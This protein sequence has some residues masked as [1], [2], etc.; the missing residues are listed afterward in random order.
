MKY[1]F[2]VLLPYFVGCHGLNRILGSPK[3]VS[4]DIAPLPITYTITGRTVAYHQMIQP[5]RVI[6]SHVV[7]EVLQG[8]TWYVCNQ[9]EVVLDPNGVGGGGVRFLNQ[10]L[11]DGGNLI[12]TGDEIAPIG[13]QYRIISTLIN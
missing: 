8:T 2:I 5:I 1:W 9:Y 11:V 13:T 3:A 12:L 7:V 4:D 6:N 10:V